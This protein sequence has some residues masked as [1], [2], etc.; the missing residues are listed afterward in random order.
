MVWQVKQSPLPS[1]ISRPTFAISSG[2][3]S[4]LIATSAGGCTSFCGTSWP[5]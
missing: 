5:T 1:M 3:M 4:L 2:F